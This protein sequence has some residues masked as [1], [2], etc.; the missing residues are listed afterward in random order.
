MFK[1]AFSFLT[2]VRKEFDLIKWI[3]RKEL[4]SYTF[5]VVALVILCSVYFIFSDYIISK[6][7]SLLLK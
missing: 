5:F 2:D 7:M 3:S 4:F 6:G 1:S